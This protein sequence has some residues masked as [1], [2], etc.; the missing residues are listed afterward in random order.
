MASKSLDAIYTEQLRNHPEGHAL[1][2]KAAGSQLRPGACGYFREIGQWRTIIQIADVE[3]HLLTAQGWKAPSGYLKVERS[4]GREWPIKLSESVRDV[5]VSVEAGATVPGAPISGG[6]AMHFGTRRGAGA[7]LITGGDV[8]CNQLARDSLALQWV[9]DS[10]N[11]RKLLAEWPEISQERRT[12]WMTTGT[13]TVDSCAI[14]VLN[15][16]ESTVKIGMDLNIADV[17]HASPSEQWWRQDT[18]KTW[19]KYTAEDDSGV[20]VFM[21]GI[22]FNVGRLRKSQLYAQYKKSKQHLH[23]AAINTSLQYLL[24]DEQAADD[25][26]IV[27]IVPKCEGE[28]SQDLDIA[29]GDLIAKGEDREDEEERECQDDEGF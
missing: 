9:L 2:F 21:S 15:S 5:N 3:P 25:P 23:R 29:V 7:I 19:N 20:V 8:M 1:Y 11:M 17:A 27:E 24:E 18:D 10:Q 14:S 28:T 12:L 16:P 6:F 22:S 13:Y 26:W 4:G